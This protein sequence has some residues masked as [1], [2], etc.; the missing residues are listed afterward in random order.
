MDWWSVPIATM[1]EP[2]KNVGI[3]YQ[4]TRGTE[5]DIENRRLELLDRTSLHAVDS[6]FNVMRQRVSYLHRAGKSRAS[7]EHYNAF[8]PYQPAMLQKIVDISRIYFN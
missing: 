2:N 7:N 1:Y 8:Q 6:Y 5:D 3:F 4:R